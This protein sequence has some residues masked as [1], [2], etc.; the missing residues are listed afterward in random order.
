MSL[1]APRARAERGRIDLDAALANA[2]RAAALF[3]SLGDIGRQ[4]RALHARSVA[5]VDLGPS[6]RRGDAPRSAG[7]GAARGDLFGEGSALNML[8]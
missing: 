1:L 5:H 4:G 7:A 6:A 8:G 2:A 3:E